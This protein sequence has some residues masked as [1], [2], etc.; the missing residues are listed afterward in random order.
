MP[1]IEISDYNESI[2]SCL[3]V[4]G[5]ARPSEGIMG[6]SRDC[7]DATEQIETSPAPSRDDG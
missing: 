4:L 2:R 6:C 1:E 5:K 7:K 3:A